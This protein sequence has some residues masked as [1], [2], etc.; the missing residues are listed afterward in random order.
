MF[1]CTSIF[2]FRKPN[3]K[4]FFVL[5]VLGMLLVSYESKSISNYEKKDSVMENM[6]APDCPCIPCTKLGSCCP[7][8]FV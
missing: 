1:T 6:V 8:N 5:F 4:T 2:I 7:C 3:M